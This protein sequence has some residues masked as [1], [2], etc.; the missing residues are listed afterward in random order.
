MLGSLTYG[1]G[2]RLG[3]GLMPA[4]VANRDRRAYRSYA[5]DLS[6][7]ASSYSPY[8]QA[9]ADAVSQY[10]HMAGGMA[11]H[12]SELLNRLAEEYENSPYQDTMLR[13]LAKTMDYNAATTGMLGST[14]ANAHLQDAL[15]NQQN[16]FMNNYINQG[17]QQS[18][19]GLS[20]LQNLSGLGYNA[21]GAANNVLAAAAANRAEAERTPSFFERLLGGIF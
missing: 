11:S 15:A 4:L 21:T 20:A 18:N 19:I 3:Q 17:L 1:L 12:P 5:G 9:G 14:S 2:Q 7:I 6:D 16:Q 13:N 10:G 8:V